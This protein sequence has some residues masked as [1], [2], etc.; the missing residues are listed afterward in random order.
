M[1]RP[2]PSA[3]ERFIAAGRRGIEAANEA[4]REYRSRGQ[5]LEANM[6]LLAA[7]VMRGRL[8]VIESGEVPDDFHGMASGIGR[9]LGEY[10]WSPLDEPFVRALREAESLWAYAVAELRPDWGP[11]PER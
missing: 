1:R 5:E 2:E 10:D 6:A 11:A 7:R 8:D 4:A 3:R 9:F